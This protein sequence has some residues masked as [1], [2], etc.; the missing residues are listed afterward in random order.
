ML[1]APQ[2]FK[3]VLPVEDFFSNKEMRLRAPTYQ[4]QV[5]YS[6]LCIVDILP[7]STDLGLGPP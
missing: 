1:V 2:T 4:F 6:V 7:F 3:S 5:F